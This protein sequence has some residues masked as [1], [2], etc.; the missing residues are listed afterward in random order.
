VL[1]IAVG[2][3]S[4]REAIPRRTLQKSPCFNQMVL[5]RPALFWYGTFGP[6]ICGDSR[7][8]FVMWKGGLLRA[9]APGAYANQPTWA[10]NDR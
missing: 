6:L 3:L 10:A 2:D 4:R 1:L 8:G 7:G 9:T 5:G